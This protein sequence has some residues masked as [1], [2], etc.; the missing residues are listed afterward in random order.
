MALFDDI[1]RKFGEMTDTSR[2][3]STIN[4]EERKINANYA[5]IGKLYSSLHRN[6]PEPE[7]VV[8]I[9][10]I[11]QSEQTIQN[12]RLQI[13]RIRGVRTCSNCGGEVSVSSAFCTLCGN[14]MPHVNEALKGNFTVCAGCGNVVEEGMRFC[15][16][17]GRPVP[18]RP[19]APA[20]PVYTPPV[21]PQ[22]PMVA[23]VVN[24]PNP[25]APAY[26]APAAPTYAEPAAPAY[27]EPAAP[28]YAAPAAPAYTAPAAPAYAEPAPVD[29][30]PEAPA[31]A[32]PEVAAV[33]HDA[34]EMPE[35]VV[36]DPAPSAEEAAYQ[37]YTPAA[38]PAAESPVVMD[39]EPAPN[40]DA[41]M[42]PQR[43]CPACG[44]Q[45][46]TGDL[47]CMNCGER[48]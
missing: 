15:I 41:D 32:E 19:A 2:L 48:I 42:A 30:A 38:A 14:P 33:A 37:T 40:V 9:Q 13:Q 24:Y 10:S 17:C 22:Q 3:N 1:G 8:F 28:A 23:P 35:P 29:A 11:A 5:Q 44:A 18:P 20:A 36:S 12:C 16:N 4:D 47:F 39:V 27:A 26:A 46:E 7:F 43:F 34:P 45:I 6:D 25:A 31:Y 21:P